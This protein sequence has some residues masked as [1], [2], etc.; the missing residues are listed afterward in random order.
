MSPRDVVVIGGGHN[1]LVA[2]VL[3][4][5]AGLSVTVLERNDRLG[6][7][8]VSQEVFPGARIS[9]YSYLVSL[10]PQELLDELGLDLELVPRRY[11]SYTPAPDGTSGLLVDGH[12][13]RATR[14]SFAAVGAAGDAAALDRFQEATAALAAGVWPTLLG[15][16]PRR[17]EVRGRVLAQPGGDRAW[18]GFVERPLGEALEEE[19]ASDLVRGM[20]L[21]DGLIGTFAEAHAGSLEQNRCFLYHVIGRGTGAWNVPRGG[22]G[23]LAEQLEERA[24][25]AGVQLLTG[26]E[27]TAVRPGG[28]VDYRTRDADGTGTTAS[29]AARTVLCGAAPAV[30][31]RLLG[32]GSAEAGPGVVPPAPAP[33]GAQAKVNLLLARLPRLKDDGVAPAAAFSGTFHVNEGYAQLAAAHRAA[34]EGRWPDPLPLEAYCHSLSDPSILSPVL[35]D[36]GAHTLTVFTLHTPHRLLAGRDPARARA[37]IQAAVLASLNSVLA[38]P[39]E[40]CL[41]VGPD[42]TPC[43]E[44]RTTADLEDSLGM[45]GGNIFHAPLAWP[46]AEDDEPLDTPARRWGVD[47]GVDG[48]LLCGAGSRRGGGV[49]GL[50]GWAAA[51]A[52]LET[53]GAGP[54]GGT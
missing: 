39:I 47:S 26:A 36:A 54:G 22:M 42:G 14:A 29:L 32:G 50:G 13:A 3:L 23:R 33:E 53:M 1:G 40:D 30:L 9:R 34:A 17:S 10:F 5:R 38:E 28:R 48:I 49:S 44:T 7:A 41:A 35:R 11:S 12:D 24:R 2:A 43:L 45:P 16:L 6:G 19:F 4:A 31:A 18:R 46:W 21:T 37:E 51:R 52:V 8:T 27:A 15:P 20:V 25:A